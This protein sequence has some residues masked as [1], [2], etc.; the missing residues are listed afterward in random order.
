MAE[1]ILDV[2]GLKTHFYTEAG[3]VLAVDGVS[4]NVLKGET[5]GLV[6][7]SGSGKSVT[8]LSVLRL[9]PRPGRI[10]EGKIG[11]QGEDLLVKTEE[12]MRDIRGGKIAIIFQDPISSLNPVFTVESQLSDVIKTHQKLSRQEI[13]NRIVE[14]LQMVGIPEPQTRM[15]E[16]PHQFSGGMKQRVAVARALACEPALLF[17]DEPTTNLDVTIQAQVLDL[18]KDL[19][20]KLGMSMV[21]ITHDMGIVADITSRVVVLYAGRVCEIAS[22]SVLYD[23]PLHPYTEALLAAVPRIDQRK[24]LQLIP[25]NIPNLISP[26]SGCRFHPRCPYAM[27]ICRDRMPELE[28]V[29]EGHFVACY[30]WKN[31]NLKGV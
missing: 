25:G 20:A 24:T 31:L 2:D 8:A 19:K 18:M 28:E 30:E 6:G 9:V 13:S 22:T 23:R 11:F 14:L 17:A 16:Y 12:E 1:D 15:R 26:P 27:D 10:V 5:L 21:M 3:I 29:E 7:E 4:F